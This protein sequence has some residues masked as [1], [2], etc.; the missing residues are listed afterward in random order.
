MYRFPPPH[1]PKVCFTPFCFHEKPTLVP[2]FTNPK[3]ISAF[4]NMVIASSLYTIS[5]HKRFH[6]N[7]LLSDSRGRSPYLQRNFPY[8]WKEK[9]STNFSTLLYIS[10]HYTLHTL[11][12]I[13]LFTQV[14][15]YLLCLSLCTQY[16]QA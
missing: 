8:H 9:A 1:D 14:I 10:S 4:I 7:A 16:K 2:I 11:H 6:W 12:T 15:V 13:H 5:A 3:R